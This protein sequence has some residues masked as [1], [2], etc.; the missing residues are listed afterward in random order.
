MRN[1]CLTLLAIGVL[2]GTLC[3]GAD[4]AEETYPSKPVTI[5]IPF[6]PGGGGDI[7]MRLVAAVAPN[8][9]NVPVVA[10]NM[11]GAG[12]AVG[13]RKALAAPADGYTIVS[14]SQSNILTTLI[15]SGMGYTW[16]DLR[17]VISLNE[18]PILLLVRKDA[19]WQTWEELRDYVNAHPDTVAWGTA[20]D[21]NRMVFSSYF[22]ES[23]WKLGPLVFYKGGG[24]GTRAVLT[25]EIKIAAE[26]V[27]P[28]MSYI[29]AGSLR[30][31]LQSGDKRL[32]KPLDK[33]PSLGEIGSRP[34]LIRRMIA[35]RADTPPAVVQKLGEIL[36]AISKDES[37]KALVKKT[38]GELIVR[39]PDEISD[40]YKKECG[41]LEV[42][43]PKVFKQ[44]Q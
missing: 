38:G 21:T 9:F 13:V 2:V 25:G 32:P 15:Q 26:A 11:A 7:W 43:A 8:H 6:A 44:K 37:F 41:I 40:A 33:V 31:L 35:V 12:G 5:I 27:T 18:E 17:P 23:G 4:A 22:M 24:D 10:V 30:A 34:M 16:R 1:I 14:I 20:G 19:P 39:G 29:E 36:M 3:I 42:E 28:A